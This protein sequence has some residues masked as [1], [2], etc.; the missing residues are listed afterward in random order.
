M[1]YF[2]ASFLP[3][4]PIYN[5]NII[6]KYLSSLLSFK[7][8]LY[9]DSWQNKYIDCFS[10]NAVSHYFRHIDICVNCQSRLNQT[11]LNLC[12]FHYF[13]V[14]SVLP[15]FVKVETDYYFVSNP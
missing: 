5:I 8:T 7:N 3:A 6:H 13:I 2:I 14:S 4:I 11:V 9:I 12:Y 1:L 15:F 10:D